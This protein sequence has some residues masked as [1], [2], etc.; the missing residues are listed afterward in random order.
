MQA[1]IAKIIA[2]FMAILAFFG[3]NIKGATPTE[4][5]TETTIT[6]NKIEIVLDS[7]YTTGCRWYFTQTNDNF[8]FIE[9][10]YVEK[11]HP[12]GMV[13]VGGQSH[14]FFEAEKEGSTSISFEYKSFDGT[15]Y[16]TVVIYLTADSDLNVATET[17]E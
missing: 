10:K 4:P 13:G 2:I 6:G 8:K 11:D 3:I 9:E 5:P 16:K 7:N 1:F 17:L 14:F 12:D 15:V